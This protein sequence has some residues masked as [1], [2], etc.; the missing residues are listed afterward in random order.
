[1]SLKSILKRLKKALP[2]IIDHAPAIIAA[3]KEVK[4]AVKP[5]KPRES[6][7]PA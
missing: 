4:A 6:E 3:L 2:V 7:T 1:M 5:D